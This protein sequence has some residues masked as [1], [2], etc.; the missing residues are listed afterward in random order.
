MSRL[1]SDQHGI[2]FRDGPTGSRAALPGG[3]DVW[4]VVQTITNG[5]PCGDAVAAAADLLNLTEP[6]IRA[7]LGYYAQHPADIDKR[8]CAADCRPTSP[9]AII[10]AWRSNPM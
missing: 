9:P 6:Q 5:K 10:E 1:P 2:I 8:I 3:P 4:E 7:A